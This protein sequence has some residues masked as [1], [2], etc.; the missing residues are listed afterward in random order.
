[1]RS[2]V[3]MNA[4]QDTS[5]PLSDKWNRNTVVAYI[6]RRTGVYPVVTC[7]SQPRF[8]AVKDRGDTHLAKKHTRTQKQRP[9]TLYH[10]P[11]WQDH[12]P[13]YHDS[14]QCQ[15]ASNSFHIRFLAIGHGLWRDVR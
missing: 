5:Q 3:R 4:K 13:G 7:R 11:I 9:I 8:K 15:K 10:P 1:M 14:Q 2:T 12:F 6:W